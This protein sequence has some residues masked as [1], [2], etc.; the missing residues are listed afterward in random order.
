MDSISHPEQ[1]AIE[2]F[3]HEIISTQVCDEVMKI[4]GQ[5]KYCR[6]TK[7][8][9][10]VKDKIVVNPFVLHK[11]LSVVRGNPSLVYIADAMSNHYR[12]FNSITVYCVAKPS[13]TLNCN[14]K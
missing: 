12:K 10:A 7:L 9:A 11:F 8:V 4:T 6:A 2:L 13:T 5:S 1:L 3:S 14:L